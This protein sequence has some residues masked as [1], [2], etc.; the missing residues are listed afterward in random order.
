MSAPQSLSLQANDFELFD[1]PEQFKLDVTELSQRWKALQAQTHPDKYVAADA[2]S[3]RLAMQWSVRVNEAYQRLRHPIT[4]GA[5][6]AEL[7]GHRINAED[8]TAMPA[9]FLMQQMEWR[10]ALDDARGDI[11]GL[12]QLADE[13]S[14]AKKTWLQQAEVAFDTTADVP[15]AVGAIR[16][17]MF[18]ERF[19][20]DVNQ[21]LDALTP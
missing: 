8:N 9:M 1:L 12:T 6:L 7:R 17:L 18:I 13:T 20:K 11:K 14:A 4:R 2:A 16:A 5:Y 3:K 15:Q 19:L 10:E 21:Q